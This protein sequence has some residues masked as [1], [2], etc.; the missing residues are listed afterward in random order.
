MVIGTA[1]HEDTKS[2]L[3]N[4]TRLTEWTVRYL[5]FIVVAFWVVCLP[6]AVRM[7]FSHIRFQK[8][9]YAGVIHISSCTVA[10]IL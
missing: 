7:L 9:G 6:L 2:D 8:F 5:L 10:T 4:S 3:F 1:M